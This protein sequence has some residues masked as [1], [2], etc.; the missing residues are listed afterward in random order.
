MTPL[1]T[2]RKLSVI[3]FRETQT[4]IKKVPLLV[5][6]PKQ[7]I[8][9]NFHSYVF[10]LYFPSQYQCFFFFLSFLLTLWD[11]LEMKK[12]KMCPTQSHFTKGTS[13]RLVRSTKFCP[14]W[15]SFY[16]AGWSNTN[17]TCCINSISVFF[18]SLPKVISK[19]AEI[20]ALWWSEIAPPKIPR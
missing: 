18:P 4:I 6:S 20:L 3:L 10:G 5:R 2:F 12:K 9:S 15:R 11:M 13:P 19:T 8:I 14:V 16:L 1:K 7:V 17:T